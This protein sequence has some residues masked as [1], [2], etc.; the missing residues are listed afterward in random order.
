[1]GTYI[2][3]ANA[4]NLLTGGTLTAG[5]TNATIV[6]VDWPGDVKFVLT[7]GTVTGGTPTLAITIEGDETADFS[8]TTTRKFGAFSSVGDEDVV[9]H[10][11]NT[12]FDAKY[13]RIAITVGGTGVYTGST[14]KMM[15]KYWLHD[16]TNSAGALS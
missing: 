15:P 14:L 7:T 8:G 2:A 4:T 5:T 9:Q 12:L 1:M 16:K 11:L 6:E 10:E 13:V 3:D